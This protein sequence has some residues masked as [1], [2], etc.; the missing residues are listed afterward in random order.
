MFK[1]EIAPHVEELARVLE[2]KV[3]KKE[4]QEELEIYLNE[5]RVSLE[6]AKRGI[7]RK[8]GGDPRLLVR[9]GRKKISEI[10][11]AEQSVDILARVISVNEKEIERE[12]DS[13]TILYGLLW[14]ETGTIPYT[15]WEGDRFDFGRNDVILIRNAYSKEWNENPQVNLGNRAIVEKQDPDALPLTED[16]GPMF[17]VG[18]DVK[19]SELQDGMNGINVTSRILS[20]ERREVTIQGEARALYSGTM[21]DETGKAQFTAWHDFDLKE[22]EVVR[23]ENAYTRS[24]RGIP[25]LNFG[26]RARVERVEEEMPSEFEL[27]SPSSRG[28][29]ELERIGGGI[30]VSVKGVVVDVKKGSGL[31]FRCPECNRQVQSGNCRIHG[32][33][34]STPDLRIKAVIDDG[35]STLTAIINRE[36]T[37]R[38]VDISL[39]DALSRARDAMDQEIIKDE[40]ED[41]LLSTPIELRGNVTSDEFGLMMRVTDARLM[42]DDVRGEAKVLLER[43]GA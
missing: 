23:I 16:F 10:G 40:M 24:W 21:A 28:I 31:I 15:A 29:I 42:R 14:D 5:Y 1:D 30:D 39:E 22:G 11:P 25:Q 26:E 38:L 17:P 4:I 34:K 6:S 19:L 27:S 20:V 33:V 13:K 7:V 3:E 35:D 12:G 9:E 37:E 41:L 36:V 43:L 18:G 8:Y 2:G 32:N